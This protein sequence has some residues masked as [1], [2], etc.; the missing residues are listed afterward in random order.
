MAD[1]P[2]A[3][4]AALARSE[5]K[6]WIP[7]VEA[8]RGKLPDC[9][10]VVTVL[11]VTLALKSCIQAAYKPDYNG[12][13]FYLVAEG[14]PLILLDLKEIGSAAKK[15]GEPLDQV[16][17]ASLLHEFGHGWLHTRNLPNTER[18]AWAAAR[19]FNQDLRLCDPQLLLDFETLVLTKEVPESERQQRQPAQP[20]SLG[21]RAMQ[22]RIFQPAFAILA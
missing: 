8:A 13:C 12:G 6:S 20:G 14:K 10:E 3:L 22:A 1:L 9:P 5:R 7:A 16:A 19:F 4:F 18:T 2:F 15:L 11:E 17:V 21:Q